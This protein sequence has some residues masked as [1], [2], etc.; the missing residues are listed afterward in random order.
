[1]NENRF[2]QHKLQLIK[3]FLKALEIILKSHPQLW[4]VLFLVILFRPESFYLLF[5]FKGGFVLNIL[6][7]QT[8]VVNLSRLFILF[9]ITKYASLLILQNFSDWKY[10][11]IKCKEALLD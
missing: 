3:Q 6:R 11:N 1:M 4:P 5:T 10:K 9:R 7:L 2:D 8:Y